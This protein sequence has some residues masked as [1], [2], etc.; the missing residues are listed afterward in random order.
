MGDFKDG[1]LLVRSVRRVTDGGREVGV[2]GEGET[3]TTSAEKKMGGG[4]VGGGGRRGGGRG[5]R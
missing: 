4:G 2:G 5:G 3:K 1:D